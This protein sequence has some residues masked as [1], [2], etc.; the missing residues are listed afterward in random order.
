M[1]LPRLATEALELRRLPIVRIEMSGGRS[2][3]GH[4]EFF[5]RRHAHW[6]LIQ[7]KKWG[8]ALAE[9]PERLEDYK[10]QTSRLM[11]RRVKHA[12]EAGYTFARIDAAERFDEMMAVNRS[13]DERQGR[14]I[15]PDYLDEPTVRRYVAQ[16]GD[17]YGVSDAGGTLRA[18]LFLRVCGE[19]AFIERLLG[20]AD[21][22]DE[23][24]MYLLI[25][26]TM[27]DLIELRSTNGGPAW[28]MYD[29]FSGAS[30]GIRD[31]KHV[32]GC[33]PYRVEWSWR[34]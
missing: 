10:R 5:T 2:C 6:K 13:A 7:N 4:F 3:R 20:H 25:M 17:V 33:R 24:V 14:P 21:A 30:P 8:V 11:R 9:V 1:K 16:S 19:V 34:A 29:M 23:G 12:T 26:G 27:E 15:H 28:F 18:Y 31:F 22:L 32:I